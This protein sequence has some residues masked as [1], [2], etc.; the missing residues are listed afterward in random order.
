[1]EKEC[2]SA[3]KLHKHANSDAK[4]WLSVINM[5]LLPNFL[6]LV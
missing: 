1:M 3:G 6:N 4:N 2:I 5:D